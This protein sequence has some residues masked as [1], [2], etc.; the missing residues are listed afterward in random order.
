MSDRLLT[1]TYPSNTTIVARVRNK[2]FRLQ[3]IAYL[4]GPH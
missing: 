2:F 1:H 4:I 3:C